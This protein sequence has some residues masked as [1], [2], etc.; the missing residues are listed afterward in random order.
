MSW[1]R[2]DRNVGFFSAVCGFFLNLPQNTITM[3]KKNNTPNL[4]DKDFHDYLEGVFQEAKGMMSPNE[5]RIMKE[6]GIDEMDAF[7][8]SLSDMGIDKETLMQALTEEASHGDGGFGKDIPDPMAAESDWYDSYESS[9]TKV[10]HDTKPQEFHL[11][12]KLNDAPVK[13]WR[14]FKVP[15]N[16]SLEALAFLLEN[17]MGWDGSHLH[18]FRR[19]DTFYK[20]PADIDY[21][22]DLGFPKRY[23]EY[24]ANDFHLGNV[25]HE[26]GDRILFEYDFGDSWKHDVWLKGIREYEPDETPKFV[27]VKGE[28]MCPPDDCGGVWGYEDMLAVVAKKRKT[29]DE[30]EMLE[31][32]AIDAGF[33][34]HYYDFEDET[35]FMQDVWEELMDLSDE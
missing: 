18:E 9:I 28:G 13:I 23:F 24:D 5:L 16:L 19:K 32:Y 22:E 1:R 11:R 33:D 35:V 2:S 34:P 12:I 7:I 17:V 14:E 25:F 3:A 29:K 15:S 20:S 26:K 27:L 30:K 6:N 21:S 8:D 31:W 10:F 4:N